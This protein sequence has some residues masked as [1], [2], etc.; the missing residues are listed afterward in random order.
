MHDIACLFVVCAVI[1]MKYFQSFNLKYFPEKRQIPCPTWV[2][3]IGL[4]YEL[5]KRPEN[6]TSYTPGIQYTPRL[7]HAVV[8][9]VL[10]LCCQPCDTINHVTKYK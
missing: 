2:Y 10:S 7:S 3:Y 5:A 4:E 9:T 1:E 6:I 8:C